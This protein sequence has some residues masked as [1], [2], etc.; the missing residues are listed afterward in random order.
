NVARLLI[1]EARWN[2]ER[3]TRPVAFEEKFGFEGRRPLVVECS[4]GE[5]KIRGAID[6]IDESEDGW[7]VID[8]KTTRTPIKRSDAIEGRN[9]QLPIYLMAA[10]HLRPDAPVSSAYYLHI[11]SRKKGSEI[12]HADDER[13]SIEGVIAHAEGKIREYTVL[14]RSGKF[15]VAPNNNR[16]HQGCEYESMCRIGSLKFE[17]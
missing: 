1:Q 16:C 6:R 10:R 13:L 4:E 12:P 8:Y 9:L 15:P 11:T 14:A 7:I 3:A 2:A 17:I 5:I